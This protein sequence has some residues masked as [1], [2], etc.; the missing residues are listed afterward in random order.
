[1]TEPDGPPSDKNWKGLIRRILYCR[2]WNQDPDKDNRFSGYMAAL[3]MAVTSATEVSA[4]AY[5]EAYLS[6]LASESQ[7]IGARRAAGICASTPRVTSAASDDDATSMKLGVSLR[8]LYHQENGEW[9]ATFES[10]GAP[11]QNALL[12]QVNSLPL[13]DVEQ[14]SALFFSLI[15]RCENASVSV[16]Y[17]DLASTLI[18]WGNGVSQSSRDVRRRL[19][20][21]FYSVP[22]IEAQQTK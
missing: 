1:M 16:N 9:P 10:D 19:L 11:R 8:H 18:F 14:A 7:R 2:A 3:R 22:P 12:N 21:S 13:L 4:Y 20:R 5:T 6:S 17:L 15:K